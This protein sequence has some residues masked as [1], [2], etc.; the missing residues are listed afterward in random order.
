MNPVFTAKN[1]VNLNGY[2]YHDFI[3]E[4]KTI[5]KEH[6]VDKRAKPFAFIV[7]DFE[8][9]THELLMQPA[10]FTELDRLSGKDITIFFFWGNKRGQMEYQRQLFNNFNRIILDQT[11][12]TV[13][14]T[15]FIVFCDFYND[16]LYNFRCYPIRDAEEFILYDLSNAINAK[17][18]QIRKPYEKT[19]LSG[20]SRVVF[21]LAEKTPTIIY[22]KFIE[23][24]FE[25]IFEQ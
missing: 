6:L 8:S 24:L 15:P 7:Y 1:E 2:N 3:R 18:K 12:K 20:L 23:K 16:D 14:S 5:C 17:L 10:I 13:E 21:K 22:T 25:N 11:N 4:F 9:V 19:S